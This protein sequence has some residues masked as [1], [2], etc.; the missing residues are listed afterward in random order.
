MWTTIAEYKEII[1]LWGWASKTVLLPGVKSMSLC[2]F[3]YCHVYV[4]I[5]DSKSN[6]NKEVCYP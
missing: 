3:L 4:S 5:F 6:L 1:N 2:L